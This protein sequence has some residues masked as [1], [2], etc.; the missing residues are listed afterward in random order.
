MSEL[1]GAPIFLGVNVVL[2]LAIVYL[3]KAGRNAEGLGLLVLGPGLI[4]ITYQNYG[5]DPQWLLMLVALLMML[6]PHPEAA[7]GSGQRLRELIHL[8]VAAGLA[9]AAPSFL[10]LGFSAYRHNA[11]D[12]S[13]YAPLLAKFPVHADLQATVL[14]SNS[15][16]AVIGLD[17]QG[18]AFA[19][20]RPLADRRWLVSIDGAELPNCELQTGLAAWYTTIGADLAGAGFAGKAIY[21]VDLLNVLYL[22]GD[23]PRLKGA[24]P[25]Y[26]GGTPGIANADYVLIPICPVTAPSRKVKLAALLSAGVVLTEVRRTAEYRLYSWVLAPGARL[27]GDPAQTP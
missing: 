26:Y 20:Y 11:V 6:R 7:A 16:D 10:N 21:E 1:L 12:T 23:F 15:V 8:T 13:A 5:N 2:I 18:T 22:F 14:V 17:G 27:P 25:W 19:A 9:F 24:A 4:Y 3:R